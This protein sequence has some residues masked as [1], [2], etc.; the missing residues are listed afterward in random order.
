M[1]VPAQTASLLFAPALLGADSWQ[2]SGK[3]KF[4]RHVQGGRRT[5]RVREKGIIWLVVS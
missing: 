5:E 4:S 3:V 2:G 1:S